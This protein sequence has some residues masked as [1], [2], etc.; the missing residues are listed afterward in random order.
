MWPTHWFDRPTFAVVGAALLVGGLIL[1]SQWFAGGM[2]MVL[3]G[4]G[5]LFG[6]A[7]NFMPDTWQSGAWSVSGAVLVLAFTVSLA[8]TL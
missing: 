5:I 3:W 1:G 8:A 7:T 2:A 4:S 6:V